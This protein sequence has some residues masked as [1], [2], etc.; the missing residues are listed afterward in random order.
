MSSALWRYLEAKLTDDSAKVVAVCFSLDQT[1][2]HRRCEP[3]AGSDGIKASV[4]N[5]SGQRVAFDRISCSR[6]RFEKDLIVG[7]VVHGAG[8]N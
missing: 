1:A 7:V 3:T 2:P 5:P 6:H 4:V 8:G